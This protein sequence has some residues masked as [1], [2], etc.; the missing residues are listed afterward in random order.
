MDFEAIKIG[1]LARR[2]DVSVRALHHYHEL[3]LLVPSFHGGSGHR[4][5]SEADLERLLRIR[6]LQQLGFSLAEIGRCLDEPGFSPLEVVELHLRGLRE[7]LAA[8]RE[9]CARLEHLASDLRT[10]G[11]ATS[12][13]LLQALRTM[14]EI[15]SYYTEEQLAQLAERRDGIGPDGM[16]RAQEDWTRLFAELRSALDEGLDPA[17]D[18]VQEL[19]ARYRALIEG[20]TGGDPGIEQSLRRMYA[21]KPDIASGH[22]YTP[23]PE[24]QTFVGA[25]FAAARRRPENPD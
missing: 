23:D 21:E 2:A 19:A 24:L 1:E 15:E 4:L 7:R 6:A 17:A 25:A 14:K 16:R 22:G 9:L 20:F 13:D 8:G 11:R 3:G 12:E 5:Y 18:R 10:K